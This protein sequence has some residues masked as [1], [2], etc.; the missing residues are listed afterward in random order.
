M[1]VKRKAVDAVYETI[2]MKG[3]HKVA[4]AYS[5]RFGV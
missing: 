3:D 4:D 1:N 5:N 2:G